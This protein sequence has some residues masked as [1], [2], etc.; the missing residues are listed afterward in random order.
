MFLIDLWLVYVQEQRST[1]PGQRAKFCP[2][3]VSSSFIGDM[4]TIKG[5][6][7]V[8]RKLLIY[9]MLGDQICESAIFVEIRMMLND[10]GTACMLPF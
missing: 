1:N 8:D 4:T 3:M 10:A 2:L 5:L 7:T 9:T 6:S